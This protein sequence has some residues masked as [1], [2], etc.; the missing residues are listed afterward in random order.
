MLSS[1]RRFQ[2]PL[3]HYL[4]QP[5]FETQYT[6]ILNLRRFWYVYHV[7]YLERCLERHFESS[8]QLDL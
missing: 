2:M 8:G 6:P 1:L 3:W 4:N 7:E 5:L